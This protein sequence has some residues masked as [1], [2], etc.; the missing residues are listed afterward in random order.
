MNG[1]NISG[2]TTDTLRFNATTILDTATNYIVIILSVCSVKDTCANVSLNINLP[3]AISINPS[4]QTVCLGSSARFITKA[5][6]SG[7]TYQWRRGNVN[8]VNGLNISGV[9]TDTLRFNA[10][11]I[12]DTATNYNVII[13]SVCSVKDTSANVS[14]NI[15]LPLAISINPSNQTVCLGSSARFITKA[16]GSG[17]TYQWRRGNVNLVNGL[18]ISGVTSDTLRFNNTTIL[19]TAANYNVI[20]SSTCSLRDTSANVSLNINLPLAISINPSNQTVCLGSSARFVT[21][22]TGSGLTYQWRRGNVNLVNGL[23]ISDVTT[24]TLRFNTTTILDTATNYNI[25][26]SSSCSL[27]DTSANVSLNINLPLVISIN[28]SNQTACLG[29]SARFITRATGSGLTYQW[30]RGNVNL[31]NGL[32]ISGVTTDTLRFNATTILDTATNYNVILSS[33]CSLNDTSINVSLNIITAPIITTE[34]INQIACT[35]S[36]VS[37]ATSVS[38]NGLNY[39]W[40]KDGIDLANGVNISGA[41]ANILTINQVA[42]SDTS[43]NYYLVVT[44]SCCVTDTSVRVSLKVNPIPLAIASSNSPICEGKPINLVAQTVLGGTYAWSGPNGFTSSAQ[45]PNINSAL[46]ADSGNYTLV[47]T[48]NGCNSVLVNLNVIVKS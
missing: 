38:G 47:V 13:S 5:T 6:G 34:P 36:S 17:L 31:V 28:P 7:L 43:L 9:T 3:L 33:T 15:N 20:I 2:V 35:G 1:L 18:N 11:T 23:N 8:L 22:A 44:N 12:L 48:Q 10:T 39:Q 19:D 4:N 41:N 21:K 24:D 29:S 46:L 42:L 32:N 45:N 26:I 16:T 14:L 27:R 25:I 30:R 40:R 37:Y